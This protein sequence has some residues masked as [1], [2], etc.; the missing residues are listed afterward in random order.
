MASMKS[1]FLAALLCQFAVAGQATGKLTAEQSAAVR[2]AAS[3]FFKDGAKPDPSL[4][5]LLA[6]DESAVR[7]L[8]WEAYKASPAHADLKADRDKQVRHDRHTSP[9]TVKEVGG[10]PANGR[11]LVIAMHGGGNSGKAVND[12]QWRTMQRYYKDQPQAGGYFYV[13]LRAPNDTW[14]GFYDDYVCP[15]IVN[16]I[17]QFTLFDG[18]DP[19]KVFILGYS[20]GGYG[21]FYLGPK[22]PD[23]FAAVHASAGAPTDKTISAKNLRNT[24]FTFMIGGK[25]TAY[26][27][28]ERNENF[29]KEIKELQKSNPGDYPVAMDLK[30]G[31]T[32][33][34][35]PDRD[36][37]KEMLPK[38]RNPVPK[39]LTWE[40]MDK[41]LTD[42][43]WLSIDK[44]AKGQFIDAKLDGGKLIVSTKGVERFS[45]HLDSRLVGDRTE[46]D[47]DLNGKPSK[48]K[49]A[50]KLQ[51]L[52]ESMAKRG[53]PKLAGACNLAIEVP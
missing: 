29:D 24:P 9:Y 26:G 41:F 1:L 22:M 45:L 49:F 44:P 11:A 46:L 30:E 20:H 15:L 32:H 28:R 38:T 21:A 25:D 7:D 10:K 53:D 18:V 42:F 8:V 39:H 3:A 6:V 33:S 27:R 34:A 16:L 35:L 50:P 40:P 51:T 5:K 2:A 12:S 47:L 23:R 13:A 48:F 37:L 43:Y 17:K 19:D 31:V 36:Q 14:N 4:D 52:C